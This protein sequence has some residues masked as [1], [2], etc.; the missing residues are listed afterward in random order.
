MR[1]HEANW[2]A[3]VAGLLFLGIGVYGIAVTPSHLADSLRWLWP[4]LLIGLG[5]ALLVRPSRSRGE[6][7]TS[8]EVGAE[9]GEDGEVEQT[10]GSHD[11]GVGTLAER[12]PG[13]DHQHDG[14]DRARDPEPSE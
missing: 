4:I 13:D 5:V 8:D 11:G 12:G 9:G 2:T 10:G 3:L 1:R 6:N 14:G 7:G